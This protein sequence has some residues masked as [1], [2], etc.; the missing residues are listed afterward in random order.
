MGGLSHL[1]GSG[2]PEWIALALTLLGIVWRV[3]RAARASAQRQGE[4][5]GELEKRAALE[6]TRRLQVESV[7]IDDGLRLPYWPPDGPIEYRPRPG[8][9]ID[10]DPAPAVDQE[11]A[12]AETYRPPVPTRHRQ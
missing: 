6:R 3:A 7:L 5:I 2:L 10:D 8:R 1:P 12:T 11:P 9:F 4:R